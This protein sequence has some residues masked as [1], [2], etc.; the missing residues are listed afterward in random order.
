MTTYIKLILMTSGL[1]IILS[2]CF[3]KSLHPLV[4]KEDAVAMD[5]ISGV[6]EKDDQRWTFIKDGEYEDLTMTGFQGNEEFS[7]TMTDE[8]NDS[9]ES[10]DHSYMVIYEDLSEN[11]IDSSYFFGSFAKLDNNFYLDLYPFDI[12]S[13]DF[14]SS[15]YLPV[16]T[17]SKISLLEDSLVISL[18]KDSWIEE[19][20]TDNRV[21]IK[22]EKTDDSILITAGTEELQKFIIKYGNMSEAYRDPINLKRI[23]P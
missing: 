13:I 11:R 22:H 18:F 3:L 5:G 12:G 15:H 7:I 17:F 19:Q 21:R 10:N 2:G 16:H 14:T 23:Q 1:S 8:D 4:N 6:W 20:I 9:S